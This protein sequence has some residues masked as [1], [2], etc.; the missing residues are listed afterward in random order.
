MQEVFDTLHRFS[1]LFSRAEWV[2][3]VA[4]LGTLL[5]ALVGWLAARAARA[6]ADV[7]K[8]QLPELRAQ[9]EAANRQAEAAQKQIELASQAAADAAAAA[10]EAIRT[11]ADQRAPQV[12]VAVLEPE[13]PPYVDRMRQSM[14][15][16]NEL[17]LLDSE[18]LERSARDITDFYLSEH[19]DW[20]MWFRGAA[21]VINEGQ[22]SARVRI[23]GEVAW[24]ESKVLPNSGRSRSEEFAGLPVLYATPVGNKERGEYLVPPNTVCKFF[25]GIGCTVREWA[26][27]HDAPLAA[28]GS[29]LTDVF[30]FVDNGTL[31]RIGTEFMARPLKPGKGGDEHWVLVDNQTENVGI[32]T[33]PAKREYIAERQD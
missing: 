23:S 7:A 32:T 30:S 13:W 5:A 9:A 28:G 8:K 4:A 26:K 3:V 21:Y 2:Q 11:R 15:L 17:R 20:L 29:F 18:S 25:W 31:D 16:K 1:E 12:V 27:K 6:A 14:P 19:G 10:R 22:T 24:M 33:Y